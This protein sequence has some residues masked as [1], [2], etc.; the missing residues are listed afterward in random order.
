MKID[1]AA[2][3]RFFSAEDA[4]CL[5]L[6]AYF[7][8]SRE[9]EPPE[10]EPWAIDGQPYASA[11]DFAEVFVREVRARVGLRGLDALGAFCETYGGWDLLEAACRI[12]PEKIR[13]L[14]DARDADNAD[15]APD[16]SGDELHDLP[17]VDSALHNGLPPELARHE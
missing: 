9:I 12:E 4:C 17:P 8:A 15:S 13:P 14:L 11:T 3:C 5:A 2:A 10:G 6:Q 7:V 1:P 16:F